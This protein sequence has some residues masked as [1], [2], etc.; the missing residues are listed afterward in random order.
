M[1][2]SLPHAAGSVPAV[3]LLLEHGASPNAACDAGPP[4][5]W[6]AG[7]GK[8]ATLEALLQA[9]AN[10]NAAGNSN[11]TPALAASAAGKRSSA[12]LA[13]ASDNITALGMVHHQPMLGSANL[14]SLRHQITVPMGL[15]NTDLLWV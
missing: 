15:S 14:T 10:P 3:K 7:S 1:F 5:M 13:A 8:S 9:G 2:S 12:N 11:V 6:A 4:V